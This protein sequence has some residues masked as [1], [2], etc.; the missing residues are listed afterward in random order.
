MDTTGEK[1][2]SKYTPG[3]WRQG[4]VKEYLPISKCREIAS[5]EGRIGL[6]YG[7]VDEE[8][9]ANAQLIAAAPDLLAACLAFLEADNQCGANLAFTMAQEAVKK[10][11]GG[12]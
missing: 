9:K 2:M 10:A 6:V 11:I 5:D 3:P 4:G 1:G 7:I 8:N 12:N